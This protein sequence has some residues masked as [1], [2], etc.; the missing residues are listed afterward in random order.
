[1]GLTSLL[2]IWGHI[3]TVP[4]CDSDTLTNVLPQRNAMPQTQDTT[5]HTVTVYR[6]GA[7]LSLCYPLMWNVTLEYTATHF[8]HISERSTDSG[9]EVVSRKLG[10]KYRTNL[11]LNP[12]PVVCES[13]TPSAGPQL[14]PPSFSRWCVQSDDSIGIT[15]RHFLQSVSSQSYKLCVT[16]RN[17]CCHILNFTNKAVCHFNI[18]SL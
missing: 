15:G 12:G 4:V 14:L 17:P 9:V 2:N 11:V 10:R 6:H 3:M 5:L 13:I 16:M 7:D 8:P 1:M 18:I